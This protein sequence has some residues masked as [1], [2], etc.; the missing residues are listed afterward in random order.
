M[1]HKKRIVILSVVSVIVLTALGFMIFAPKFSVNAERLSSY[2]LPSALPTYS[3][4]NI[5]WQDG[6]A[7]VGD[8]GSQQLFYN[9]DEVSFVVK[10][11]Q[12]GYEWKSGVTENEFTPQRVSDYIWSDLRKACVV[13]YTNFDEI[14]GTI[15]IADK[16]MQ[17]VTVTTSEKELENGVAVNLKFEEYELGFTIEIWLA[18]D[19]L[20][21]RVP[22]ESISEGE[23]YGITSISLFP[24]FGATTDMPNGYIVYP[25]GSGSLFEFSPPTQRR[26][27]VSTDIYF[28]R[29]FDLDV[30]ERDKLEGLKYGMLPSYGISRGGNA[31]ISYILEG[32]MNS[33]VTL[34]PSGNIYDLNRINPTI[35]YRKPY[36]YDSPDGTPLD[37]VEKNISAGDFT[38][39]YIFIEKENITYSDMANAL[40]DY[41]LKAGRIRKA[42]SVQRE[43]VN[44]NLQ[45]I[46]GSEVESMIM[47]RYQTMTTFKDIDN[48][49]SALD[50]SLQNKM[51]ILMLGWQEHGYNSN[52]TGY[53]PARE[54]GAVSDLKKLTQSLR[55]NDIDSYLIVNDIDADNGA[56]GFTKQ[57]DAAYNEMKLPISNYEGSRYLTNP[58]RVLHNLLEKQLPYF[59]KNKLYGVGFD[60]IGTY[61]YDDYQRNVTMNRKDTVLAFRGMLLEA[62]NA[63]LKT[64]VQNGNAYTLADV[65]YLYDVPTDSSNITLMTRTIPF[66]QLVVHGIIPYSGTIPANMSV[67][68]K[69]EK[70]KWIEYG[71]EPYF[72][73]TKNPSELFKY[74]KVENAFATQADAWLDDIE[75]VAGEF[76][77]KLAFTANHMIT[78]HLMLAKDLYRLTYSNGYRIYINYS[79]S[80]Q[81]ADGL[82]INAVDYL[83]VNNTASAVE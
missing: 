46:M 23:T 50:P 7:L 6:I 21:I 44:V 15:N 17:T 3:D 45:F 78:E 58:Y 35:T 1:K 33:Y 74:S 39:H 34:A 48:I 75:K 76:N 16:D 61:V 8:D 51:R 53:K 14:N 27:T 81:S 63:G 28:P 12:S 26:S 62:K 65:D 57:S 24:M 30:I 4:E 56:S 11:K 32:E 5:A 13:G 37:A 64:A 54:I 72:L 22:R 43:Q 10:S 79:D 31:L 42:E 9:R 59:K 2:A 38:V 29:S 69:T 70:L 60:K 47:T 83:V 71:C 36:T 25:D 20:N 19:G 68:Y 52:P 55:S 49:I 77:I 80:V 18:G 82:Q 41:L 67:D 73:L 40:R 66:Y